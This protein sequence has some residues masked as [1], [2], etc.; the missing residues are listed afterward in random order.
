MRVSEPTLKRVVAL[1]VFVVLVATAAW[2]LYGTDEGRRL[3][4]ANIVRQWSDERPVVMTIVFVILYTTVGA[5][6]LPVFWLQVVAGDCFGTLL[7]VIWCQTAA[8]LAS[9]ISMRLGHWLFGEWFRERVE[10]HRERIRRLDERLGH[11]GLLV[12][13]AV[14]LSH[15]TPFGLSNYL[16]S[17]TRI[18]V[19]DVVV[20]TVLGGTLSKML[21]VP[22]GDD[23]GML[24]SME[25]W[26]LVIAVNL[27]LVSPLLLRYLFPSWFRRVG[28]E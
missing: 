11:N 2:F 22:L 25:Y 12:V 21:H 10:A 6:A 20:G 4:E 18:S 16:F 23:P 14:R 17:V 19:I 8:V 27:L 15:L 7:G 5:L 26:R 13:T 28:I 9:I 1:T 24:V 3:R